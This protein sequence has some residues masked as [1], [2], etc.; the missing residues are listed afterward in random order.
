MT[1]KSPT[2]AVVVA[3]AAICIVPPA[4]AEDQQAEPLSASE[5]ITQTVR[6]NTSPSMDSS[7]GFLGSGVQ[8]VAGANSTR[9]ELAMTQAIDKSTEHNGNFDA[10]TLKLTAPLDEDSDGGSFL[11]EGGLADD[12]SLE[13]SFK[14][15]WAPDPALV[16]SPAN[17]HHLLHEGRRICAERA[18]ANETKKKE[19]GKLFASELGDYL[20]ED[21][22]KILEDSDWDN[23][24][25]WI[26]GL[27]SAIGHSKFEFRDGTSFAELSETKVPW[28]LSANLGVNPSSTPLFFGGGYEYKV[29]YD[30]ADD[31]AKCQN[32]DEPILTCE[33]GAFAP[34]TKEVS[35]S[36]FAV[37]RTKTQWSPFGQNSEPLGVEFKVSYDLK[38]EIL[39]VN[40]PVYLFSDK[41]KG[42]RGGIK[43]NWDDDKKRVFAGVFIGSTFN[44]FQ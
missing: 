4:A 22:M 43:L 12:T 44:I 30:A 3:V 40:M 26:F 7:T 27:S 5:A 11:G 41:D 19:C 25:T 39:S 16:S 35:S 2:T 9:I 10:Y 8:L 33:T 14:R 29:N 21:E 15:V 18:G 24:P 17:R 6:Q 20:S 37:A 42:L 32:S 28:S 34:P 38:K 31:S 23:S 1:H 13:L 36:F